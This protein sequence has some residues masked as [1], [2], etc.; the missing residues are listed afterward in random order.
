MTALSAGT[1][2][3][4]VVLSFLGQSGE[5]FFSLCIGLDVQSPQFND[6]REYLVDGERVEVVKSVLY[7]VGNI[8]ISM[9]S[10]HGSDILEHFQ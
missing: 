8:R 5:V 4:K 7:G 2:G 9:F 1:A 3:E 10:H 6:L